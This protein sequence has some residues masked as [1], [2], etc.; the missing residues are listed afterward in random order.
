MDQATITIQSSTVEHGATIIGIKKDT[1]YAAGPQTDAVLR[2]LREIQSMGG[3]SPELSESLRELRE[4]IEK[5]N[6]PK[7][8]KLVTSIAS[9][10]AASL[11]SKLAGDSLKAFLGIG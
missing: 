4:A 3:I 10:T 2:D 8:S 1:T 7:I 5:Q 11:L 6:Q 9:G